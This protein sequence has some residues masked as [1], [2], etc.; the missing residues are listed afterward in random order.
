M[1]L[2][3]YGSKYGN[4]KA[5]AEMLSEILSVKA[6]SYKDS[7]DYSVIDRIIYIGSL[8]AGQALGLKSIIDD[9]RHV[10]IDKLILITV[11]LSDPED[12]A[13]AAKIKQDMAASIPR[14]LLDRTEIYHLR[15]GIDYKNLS[16]IHRIM[17]FG[18]NL[19]LKRLPQDEKNADVEAM[20]TSYGKKIVF[21]DSDR[22]KKLQKKLR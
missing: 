3:I 2:I 22:L 4:G 20:I 14:D 6:I 10:D 11:G 1:D 19:Y 15:G 18:M 7:I 16:F 21:D 13:G 12:E 9:L 5:Y 8:Y 17:M